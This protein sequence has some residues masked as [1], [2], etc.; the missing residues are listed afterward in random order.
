MQ[1]QVRTQWHASGLPKV[2]CDKVVLPY[3]PS[4]LVPRGEKSPKFNL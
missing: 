2:V 3:D 4:A 1:L